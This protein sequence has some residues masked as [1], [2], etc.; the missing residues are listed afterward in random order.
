M[1]V[2]QGCFAV[3]LLIA[4]MYGGHAFLSA[5]LGCLITWL[6]N[7]GFQRILSSSRA[8]SVHRPRSACL[9]SVYVNANANT[10]T[11]VSPLTAQRVIK[12]FYIAEAIKFA[13]FIPL[14]IICLKISVLKPLWFMAYLLGSQFLLWFSGMQKLLTARQYIFK[15]SV[16]LK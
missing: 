8:S 1:L 6:P 13:L 9:H 14:V 7:L 2:I 12:K 16:I 3:T 11:N 15:G 4:A 10:S 5:L